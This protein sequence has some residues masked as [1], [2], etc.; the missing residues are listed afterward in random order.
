MN[1]T[2]PNSLGFDVVHGVVDLQ[3]LRHG[4]PGL[5]AQA[6]LQPIRGVEALSQLQQIKSLASREGR[7][8]R[9]PA[10]R[11]RRAGPGGHPPAPRRVA[12]R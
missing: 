7:Q 1:S 11:L 6:Q 4:G 5:Q 3:R 10:V 8:G 2:Y 12:R 9:G